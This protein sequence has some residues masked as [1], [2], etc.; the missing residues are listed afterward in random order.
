MTDYI[1]T[2]TVLSG[3]LRTSVYGNR[4][5]SGGA[6]A[7]HAAIILRRILAERSRVRMVFA[8][9]PSQNEFL[10]A[11][12]EEKNIDWSRIDAFHMDEYIGLPGDAP[13]SFGK[14]LQNRL[15]DRVNP[16]AVYLLDT[17][18]GAAEEIARYGTLIAEAPIDMVCLGIGENGHLAFNDPPVADF[19]D[20]K[21]I[22]EVELDL[23]CRQQQVNDGCFASLDEVP[24]YALT[25]TIPTLMSASYLVCNVPGERKHEAIRQTLRGDISTDWPSTVL[26][27][28]PD[29]ALFTDAAGFGA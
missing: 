24:L 4:E 2:H 22:K 20:P 9:A 29:C 7:A 15:F 1:P 23:A 16:G 17:Q 28:H 6:A 8:A 26:R 27:T 13:Q 18:H 19:Q 25:L 3:A 21:L 11:L 10:D 14:Y 5:I 12:A